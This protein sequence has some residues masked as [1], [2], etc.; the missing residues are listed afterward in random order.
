MHLLYH[1]KDHE[2]PPRDRPAVKTDRQQSTRNVDEIY[3][4]EDW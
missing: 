3:L 4:R 1:A 2:P